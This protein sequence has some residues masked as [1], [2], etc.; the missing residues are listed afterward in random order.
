[1]LRIESV[2]Q[3]QQF[4]SDGYTP[5]LPNTLKTPWSISVDFFIFASEQWFLLSIFLLLIYAFIW[6]E[7][8]KGGKSISH[9]ML[10]KMINADEAFVV[11]IRDAKD[12]SSGY[13]AGAYNIPF[14]K[15]KERSSEL[16]AHKDKVIVLVDKLG[17]QTGAV[18][19]DLSKQGYQINRLSGGMTEWVGEKLPVVKGKSGKG[20][21][22][23]KGK[24]KKDK[25]DK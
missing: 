1:M 17:Q 23:S 19:R 15:M 6:R 18:G 20:E 4:G 24:S 25:A 5:R 22:K 7:T 10:T 14:A 12:F 21:K 8:T 13:I 11:D 16:D 3:V 9:H 2:E